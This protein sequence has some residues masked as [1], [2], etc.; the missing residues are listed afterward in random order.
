VVNARLVG[1]AELQQALGVSRQRINQITTHGDFPAPLAVLKMG[2]VWDLADVEAWA[3]ERGRE[4][5]PL[6][7]SS[8]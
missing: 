1:A 7:G 2:K 3:D 6:D 8:S 4:L 5:A